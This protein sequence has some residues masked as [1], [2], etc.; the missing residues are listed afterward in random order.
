MTATED[1]LLDWWMDADDRWHE[2]EPP[3]AWRRA[4]DG[5]WHAPP[6]DDPVAETQVVTRVRWHPEIVER[7]PRGL[8]RAGPLV[9]VLLGAVVGIAAVVTSGDGL[10]AGD[11]DTAGR[12]TIVPSTES[13]STGAAGD[14]P[15]GTTA[16]DATGDPP[17][18]PPTDSP[19]ETANPAPTATTAPPTTASPPS[20]PTTPTT[21]PTTI[22]AP[23]L[24]ALCGPEGAIALLPTGLPIVCTVVKC[25]GAPFPQPRWREVTC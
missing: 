16:S 7:R 8:R 9:V 6:D 1:V 23:T 25:H 13:P 5:R 3:R 20:T 19:P 22:P 24:R 11:V 21:V 14:A 17:G 15:A 10:G 18:T 4:S 2:G 12:P